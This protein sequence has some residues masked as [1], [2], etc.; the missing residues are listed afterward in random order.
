MKRNDVYPSRFLKTDD[1]KEE[2]EMTLTIRNVTMEKMG[3]STD[4]EKPVA[5][6]KEKNLTEGKGLV[7]SPSKWDMIAGMYG[8]DSDGWSGKKII[9]YVGKVNYPKPNTDS[10]FIKEVRERKPGTKV[11]AAPVV[12]ED[13]DDSDDDDPED[14]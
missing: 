9:L 3:G 11:N 2:G 14:D 5:W 6:F 10:I 1:V 7:V 8:D 4:E 12:S 13:A